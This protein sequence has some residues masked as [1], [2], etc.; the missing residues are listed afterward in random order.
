L[1]PAA[2]ALV[3]VKTTW[4]PRVSGGPVTVDLADLA[5]LAAVLVAAHRLLGSRRGGLPSLRR[6]WLLWLASGL[7][8]ADVVAGS[9]YPVLSDPHYRWQTH[10]VTAA[11]YGEYA[12]LALCVV[13]LA[14]CHSARVR[15]WATIVAWA[16]L[17]ALV[18][19]LQFAGVPI[20]DPSPA[21]QAEPS[22]IGNDQSGALGLAAIAVGFLGLLRP[23]SISRRLTVA[24]LIAG[25]LGV[26]ICGALASEVGL[27]L[28]VTAVV[29][30]GLG[31]RELGFRKLLVL[32]G[33]TAVCAL[34]LLAIRGGDVYQFARYLGLARGNAAT[35]HR[36]QTYAQRTLMLYIGYRVWW[37][38]PLLGAGWQSIRETAV[39][40]PFLTAAH[41]RFPDQP[42][43]AFPSPRHTWSIDN[44]YLQTLSDLGLVG[45]VVFLALLVIALIAGGNVALHG[46]SPQRELAVVGLLWVVAVVGLW[47]GQ[48]NVAGVPRDGLFWLGIGAIIAAQATSPERWTTAN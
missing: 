48:P 38:H 22:F 36:V 5:V 15:L 25:V 42:A 18:L 10:L 44:G 43:E 29:V 6:S 26:V 28:A 4:L 2:T 14:G 9:L 11:K 40:T 24:A 13:T 45:L 27:V 35:H 1:L 19:G 3:F 34:G 33:V 41:R 47:T 8:L 39:Y 16:S 46:S 21:G 17:S 20:F 32:A 30:L 31:R 12:L 37:A 23:G 7:V